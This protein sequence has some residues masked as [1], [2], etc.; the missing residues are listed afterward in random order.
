LPPL[1]AI[2]GRVPRLRARGQAR[3]SG[4]LGLRASCVQPH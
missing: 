4:L 2:R 3:T 1:R